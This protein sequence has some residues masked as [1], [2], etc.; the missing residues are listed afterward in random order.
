MC[1]HPRYGGCEPDGDEA[2]APD[3]PWA[4]PTCT[5]LNPSRRQPVCSVCLARNPSPLG[6]KGART[7]A[8]AGAADLYL[9]GCPEGYW[10]CSVE[11]GGCSKFNPNGVFYCQV[12]EKVRPSLASVRF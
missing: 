10:V 1:A 2:G 9:W 3:A 12:C 4:C 8:G 11:H 6:E 5:F 7:A